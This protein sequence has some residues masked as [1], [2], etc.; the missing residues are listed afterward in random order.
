M[1]FPFWQKQ[2]ARATGLVRGHSEIVACCLDLSDPRH[3][4]AQEGKQQ[5]QQAVNV[6]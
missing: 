6:M 2:N 5:R 4:R 1:I 3:L